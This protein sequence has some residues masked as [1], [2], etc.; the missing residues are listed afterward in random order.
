M[1]RERRRAAPKDPLLI[2]YALFLLLGAGSLFPWNA[3]IT[4][5]AYF[6][7]R[8][9][10]TSFAEVFENVFSLTNSGSQILGLAIA[11]RYGEKASLRLRVLVPL[12]I[13]L[14]LFALTAALVF[15]DDERVG[16]TTLFSVTVLSVFAAGLCGA[17]YTGGVFG[18][19]ARF[20]PAYTQAAMAGQGL[21]G[22]IVSLASIASLA[23]GRYDP[24]CAP[25]GGAADGADCA[26]FS[27]DW[28]AFGYFL[29]SI[30]VLLACVFGYG[31]LRRLPITAHY[32][33]PA[34]A[35]PAR[36]SDAAETTAALLQSDE[37]ELPGAAL[38][39]AEAPDDGEAEDGGDG[40]D[41]GAA[42]S[43]G[44][45]PAGAPLLAGEG[46]AGERSARGAELRRVV[47]EV[48]HAAFS[49][50]FV[51][52]VTIAVFPST[53]SRIPSARRCE[54]GA[55]RFQNQLFVPFN[56]LLFNAF[57]LAGRGAA[58]SA[59]SPAPRPAALSLLSL[60]RAAFVPL[61]MLCGVEGSRLPV[62]FRGDAWPLL[63]MVLFAAS[64][65]WIASRAMMAAPALVEQRLQ[66]IAGTAM[67]FFL[68]LGLFAGACVSFLV[69]AISTG[70]L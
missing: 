52:C 40:G 26:P 70:S 62:A 15:V 8:F 69:Q 54:A 39:D 48:R 55:T 47:Y 7:A 44:P 23:A 6:E 49:V 12:G 18:L 60:S 30:A 16:R 20:P 67:V 65:G 63:F 32:A 41:G 59:W 66:E 2:A 25:A 10:S 33:K 53:T 3:F 21:A 14:S 36:P 29:V 31:A 24:G 1:E 27:I 28:S 9:C 19:A 68:T 58:G 5:S 22:V 4:A 43:G 13:W 46:G 34:A 35:A 51:F 11:L 57:D 17:C 45:R 38:G 42:A 56:F 61:F 64:N 50:F 37:L